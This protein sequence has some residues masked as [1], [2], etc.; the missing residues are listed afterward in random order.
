METAADGGTVASIRACSSL[1]WN[2]GSPTAA[3]H[4]ADMASYNKSRMASKSI[5]AVYMPEKLS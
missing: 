3:L 5:K 1:A 4:K 2:L